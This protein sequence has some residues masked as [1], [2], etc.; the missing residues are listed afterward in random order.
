MHSPL[1]RQLGFAWPPAVARTTGWTTPK[2]Q[3]CCQFEGKACD[4]AVATTSPPFD[5]QAGFAN[6]QQGW[7][8]QKKGWCCQHAGRG[9]PGP[10][11][12]AAPGGGRPEGGGGPSLSFCCVGSRLASGGEGGHRG[13]DRL[14]S[15]A[16]GASAPTHSGGPLRERPAGVSGEGCSSLAHSSQAG[17]VAIPTTM[18]KLPPAGPPPIRRV[19]RLERARSRQPSRLARLRCMSGT[20]CSRSG[21]AGGAPRSARS[22]SSRHVGGADDRPNPRRETPFH[23]LFWGRGEPN[24][25]NP[26]NVVG[27]GKATR[28]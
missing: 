5:C 21:Q 23:K 7:A 11:Q 3:F 9:C 2:K 16:T 26:R 25:G 17:R 27:G 12:A 6:W 20:S 22:A 15:G 8:P 1:A 24:T 13:W 4:P 14:G 10:S 28:E 19:D 18:R